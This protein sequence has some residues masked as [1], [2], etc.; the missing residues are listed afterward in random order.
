MS[1]VSAISNADVPVYT[2]QTTAFDGKTSGSSS[3]GKDE[4]LQLLVTQLQYQ[5]PTAPMDD[6]E[7]IAQMA[8][9]SSLEQMTNLNDSFTQYKAYSLLGKNVD[10]QV[11]DMTNSKME[12]IQGYVESI[13]LENNKP[14]VVIDGRKVE[15]ETISAINDTADELNA[16]VGI[17][18]SVNKLSAKIDTLSTKIESL[19]TNKNDE[20]SDVVGDVE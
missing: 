7:F 12:D 19:A 8:Q 5:D 3:L 4:F 13:G 14:F 18:D 15:I 1:D 16:M 2:R 9:F 6:K 20:A 11:K 10:A 17:L